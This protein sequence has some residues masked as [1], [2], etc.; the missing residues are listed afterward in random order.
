MSVNHDVI[1]AGLGA[2]GSASAFHLARRGVKVLGID[3]FHPPHAFGSSHGQT[4]IIREAYFEDPA[5]VPLIQRAYELWSELESLAGARLFRQTGGVMI[6]RPNSAVVSGARCSAERHGLPHKVLT[7]SETNRRFPSQ[8]LPED[9]VA[10]WEPRAGVLFPEECIA[11]HLKQA[12]SQ[13]AELH[14]EELVEAWEPTPSGVRL[15]TDRSTYEA[16]QLLISAGSWLPQLTPDLQLPLVVERQVLHWFSAARN[17][18]SFSPDRC[19]VYIWE[20]EPGHHFYGFPDL[21]NGIKVA[22][23]HHGRQVDPDTI[24][25]TVRPSEIEAM[26]VLLERF[27]PD[28]AGKHLSSVVCMYTNTPDQHFLIDRH[29]HHAQVLIA[30]PCSGHG[31]KFSSVV[32]EVLADLMTKGQSGLDLNLFRYRFPLP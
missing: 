1:I 8:R 11:A 26:R 30:S 16:E 6:G 23:H 13:N 12:E 22:G 27:L 3:R 14:F 15:K 25:R 7:A 28:A 5:Y 21:G 10:V 19:P 9:C 17:P 24:D 2:M 31:F 4:R 18:E 20:P 29:P 32:G